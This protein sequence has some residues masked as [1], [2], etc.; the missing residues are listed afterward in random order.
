M[1]VVL[2]V[3]VAVSRRKSVLGGGYTKCMKTQNTLDHSPTFP[4]PL[5]TINRS[6]DSPASSA[7]GHEPTPISTGFRRVK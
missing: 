2:K 5:Y 3:V 7:A 4:F 1:P 6:G